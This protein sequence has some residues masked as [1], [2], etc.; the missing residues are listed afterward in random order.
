MFVLAPFLGQIDKSTRFVLKNNFN[1]KST[2]KGKI[3][4]PLSFITLL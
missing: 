1:T 3:F 2:V 4:I